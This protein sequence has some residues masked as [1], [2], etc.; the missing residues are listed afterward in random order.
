MDTRSRYGELVA[1]LI[2]AGEIEVT[3][4]VQDDVQS[5][6]RPEN[7]A[8][9][10]CVPTPRQSVHDGINPIGA[11]A[12]CWCHWAVLSALQPPRLLANVTLLIGCGP[13][14]EVQI[15]YPVSDLAHPTDI[16]PLAKLLQK[17]Q[18]QLL[19]STCISELKALLNTF[20][21]LRIV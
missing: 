13:D 15:R 6:W 19:Y 21:S 18:Q 7:W 17:Q 11:G 14:G 3:A 1:S 20:F 10:C 16:L 12:G 4:C 5:S 2:P 9:A 8:G